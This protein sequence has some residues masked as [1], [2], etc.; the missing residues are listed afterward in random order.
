MLYVKR[1]Y[2]SRRVGLALASVLLW[3]STGTG[4]WR[5]VDPNAVDGGVDDTD[6]DTDT[7]T[8]DTAYLDAAAVTVSAGG[9]NTCA[10]TDAGRV[11]CWGSN[12]AGASGGGEWLTFPAAIFEELGEDLVGVSTGG[13]HTC[14]LTS[15]GGVRCIGMNWAG[16]L[17]T[18]EECTEGVDDCV[19]DH[20]VVPEGLGAGVVL[21]KTGTTHTC[22]IKEGG[23][24][25][26][27]GN[28][29][30]GQA[31]QPEED[32]GFH[33]VAVPT[34]VAGLDQPV[35]AV[36]LGTWH[37]CALLSDGSTRCWG[38]NNDGELGVPSL[39][40]GGYATPVTPVGL[41]SG[42]VAL[43]AG[44]QI[45]CALRST[46][47]LLCWGD[48]RGW[49][50]CG[51]N[52]LEKVEVPTA[53]EGL[54]DG[55]SDVVM[56]ANYTCVL[57]DS[58]EVYCMG[59]GGAS[60]HADDEGEVEFPVVP[61]PVEGLP[62]D[63]VELSGGED[64][65]CV[66]TG[67]GAI[68]CWGGMSKGQLGTAPVAR[69]FVVPGLEED[70][71]D[72]GATNREICGLK[73]DGVLSCFEIPIEGAPRTSQLELGGIACSAGS[74]HHCVVDDLGALLCWGDNRYSQLGQID[75]LESASPVVVNGIPEVVVDVSCRGEVSIARTES[76]K[77][78]LVGDYYRIMEYE[79]DSE[80]LSPM[81]PAYADSLGHDNQSVLDGNCGIRSNGTLVCMSRNG[82]AT[83]PYLP[84][85]VDQDSS[86]VAQDR[87][88]VCAVRDGVAYCAGYNDR[89]ELGNGEAC[90][91]DHCPYEGPYDVTGL[92][93]EVSDV[94][95]GMHFSCA[96]AGD[97]GV[98][99]WGW[100]VEG[101]LGD[102]TMTPRSSPSAV[103][104][105][106][107]PVSAVESSTWR[108]CALTVEGAVYC[109]GP[110]VYEDYEHVYGGACSVARPVLG[111]EGG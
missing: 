104:G 16:Q 100:N 48:C 102:G 67:A 32:D 47:E 31:G 61:H 106:P 88:H 111:F 95:V 92:E 57:I 79:Y 38:W 81:P 18:T 2:R 109:W 22:A 26:C 4:C 85:G 76:G 108:S 46:G 43:A 77:A 83:S 50:E 90:E 52:T 73:E 80:I 7:D 56:G 8:E 23:E 34:L 15:A 53:V 55:V 54:P 69:A 20:A 84:E 42:V 66:M 33:S 59:G 17:G 96:L 29:S 13:G 25:Y 1:L 28:N 70:V 27:F 86:D 21:V 12:R 36:A 24:V 64:H 19:F 44:E 65:A 41:E 91:E 103:V 75:S 9:Y 89:G 78:F 87:D 105:I 107:D 39:P 3:S 97:G 101:Q 11:A 68:H 99:C 14:A 5:N 94:G 35:V 60:I 63:I 72:F 93:G 37:T 49:G 71:I 74:A 51:P 6:G 98:S 110:G 62:D 82:T 40:D 30:H 58:G 10:V 45:S